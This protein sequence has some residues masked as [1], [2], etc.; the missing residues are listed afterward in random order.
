[1]TASTLPFR[2]AGR[3]ERDIAGQLAAVRS[4]AEERTHRLA[5][6][7]AILHAMLLVHG[8]LMVC[9]GAAIVVSGSAPAVRHGSLMVLAHLPGWP[10][11]WGIAAT[12]AGV[13]LIVARQRRNLALCRRVLQVMTAWSAAYGLGLLAGAIQAGTAWYPVFLYAGL[14]VFYQLHRVALA[15]PG[16]R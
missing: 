10:W 16:L 8:I 14:V 3:P 11:S 7:E 4:E 15:T 6:A 1:M 5:Q 2:S 13:V 9:I 12:A